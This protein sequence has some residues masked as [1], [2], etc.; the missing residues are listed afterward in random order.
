VNREHSQSLRFESQNQ[1][2]G[3]EENELQDEVHEQLM[4][5][6]L[7]HEH[8][9]EHA[10][11]HEHEQEHMQR[12]QQIHHKGSQIATSN[13]VSA[14][15][16]LP[17]FSGLS[18]MTQHYH[19]Q[20]ILFQP[21]A[22]HQ[23]AHHT[24]LSHIDHA[25]PL[26]GQSN[27]DPDQDGK[28]RKNR[29]RPT[30]D[31]RQV[32]EMFW[33]SNP[34]PDST[35]KTQIVNQLGHAVTYKQVTSWF[36]HKRESAKSEKSK[37]TFQTKFASNPKFTPEQVAI[38]EHVFLSDGYAKGKI[39][40]DLASQL[41]LSGTSGVK[42]VQNWF[43]HKRSRMAQIGRFSYKPR[44]LLNQH[45][46]TFL[47][48]AF[49]S[50]PTPNAELCEEMSQEL[51]V[52]QEQ[53]SRWFSNERSRKRKRE[54]QLKIDLG[55]DDEEGSKDES[56]SVLLLSRK[57]GKQKQVVQA[58]T[59]TAS[60]LPLQDAETDHDPKHIYSAEES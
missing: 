37:T 34:Y 39:L 31:Q 54:E 51:N 59:D 38:L 29:W 25:A 18:M 11:E 15:L 40:S 9:Q 22:G 13:G 44:N 17:S 26:L 48:G 55:E 1:E 60:L 12:H 43:K 14:P 30:Q 27:D 47:R 33:Q 10:Q 52:K 53:I 50:N 21:L 19:R 8:E 35:T 56:D 36:K 16:M 42:R 3:R 49:F 5:Q 7:Q 4:N 20:Q 23:L 45:Q 32:L 41:G 6:H 2:E 28:D 46:I 57:R 58:S 24:V